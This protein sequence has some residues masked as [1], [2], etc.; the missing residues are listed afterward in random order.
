[1]PINPFKSGQEFNNSC[2]KN[3]SLVFDSAECLVYSHSINMN[4]ALD[5]RF[6]EPTNMASVSLRNNPLTNYIRNSRDEL[7]KVS[8]P[9]REHVIRDTLI[10]IGI[11]LAIGAFFAGADKLFELG[12]QQLM[13][14]R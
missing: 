3:A 8:W 6:L 4:T 1:M 13:N 2:A 10:V 9:T 7:K 12:F 14:L 11:S 5:R